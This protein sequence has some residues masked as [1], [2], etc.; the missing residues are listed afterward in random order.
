MYEFF[1]SLGQH[2]LNGIINI[3]HWFSQLIQNI[4]DAF[5]QFIAMIFQ[6]LLLFFQGLWYL[7]TKVF[8]IVVLAVQVI[9]GL[10]KVVWSI[11]AGIFHTFAGLM[12][13]SG[14]TDYYYLPGAYQQGWDGVAGFFL[15]TGLNTIALVAC[16][17]V[18]ILTAWA[19][20]KIAGG[21]R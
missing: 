3:A 14:S 2:I 6:P 9:F 18:W 12:G 4:W 7:I 15:K 11:V 10:F 13:F 8:D 16:V 1:Q 21:E 5:K 17:F 20:I 19:V